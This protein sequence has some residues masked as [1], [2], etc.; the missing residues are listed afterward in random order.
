MATKNLIIFASGAGSNTKNIIDFFRNDP[1]VHIA[2]IV[3][4]KPEAGVLRIAS[5]EEIPSLVIEKEQFFRGNAYVD[6]FQK[7]QPELIILAGFLWKIPSLLI[8][9]FPNK[10]I[11]I[12]PA[13]LPKYGGKG[14]Y[15]HFV[16]EAVKAAGETE[17]GITIHLVD[18]HYD[19]GDNIFQATIPLDDSDTPETIAQKVH[20]LE[21]KYFP[22]IIREILTKKSVSI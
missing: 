1:S 10:I 11:N 4:N 3:S 15:G 19:H 17:T 13:L 9:S 21:Y 12:H 16:H 18:E 7:Y 2:L 5:D 20:Q 8:D 22:E 6:V 14:M